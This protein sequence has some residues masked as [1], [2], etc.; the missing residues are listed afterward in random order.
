MTNL[1]DFA[2]EFSATERDLELVIICPICHETAVVK[3]NFEDYLA[4]NE[5]KLIQEAFP[6]LS[7]ND[8]ERVKTGICPSC[9]EKMF[10]DDEEEDEEEDCDYE[11]YDYDFDFG[12]DPYMGCYTGDC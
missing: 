1:R 7:A 12:Y 4:W 10:S 6:Y 5:G 11:E 8:R 9:W 3:V 2:N